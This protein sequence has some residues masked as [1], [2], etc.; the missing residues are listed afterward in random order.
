MIKPIAAIKK[1]SLSLMLGSDVPL[2]VVGDEK[3]LKQTILNVAGNAMKFTKEGH[4]SLM[5]CVE[6]PESPR[7]PRAPEF[8][9]VSSDGYFHLRVQV[10]GL[11]ICL[12][13]TACDMENPPTWFEARQKVW[14]F[15]YHYMDLMPGYFYLPR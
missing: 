9:P 2:F 11:H 15:C 13:N 14:A 7:D 10:D 1:L 8:Y 6:K 4:V 3:R 12:L 5:A